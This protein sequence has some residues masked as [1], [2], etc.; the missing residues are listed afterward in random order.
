MR[1]RVRTERCEWFR[2]DDGAEL[3]D[4]GI[5]VRHA[6]EHR[7]HPES[8]ARF[9]EVRIGD[10][11]LVRGV[12]QAAPGA[13]ACREVM[14]VDVLHLR[15]QLREERISRVTL[16]KIGQ[17]VQRALRLL[18]VPQTYILICYWAREPDY[19]SIEQHLALYS[20]LILNFG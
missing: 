4:G 14:E 1:L 5:G 11:A 9:G 6:F 19:K 10:A 15:D 20:F 18:L 16:A 2:G 13:K 8:R 3:F 7:R 17:E 12:E